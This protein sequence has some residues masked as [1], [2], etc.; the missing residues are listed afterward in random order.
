MTR[1]EYI[2]K[3]MQCIDEVHPESQ[4]DISSCYSI[5]RFLDDAALE[6]LKIAPKHRI[7]NR[8]DFADHI[9][10]QT[11]ETTGRIKTPEDFVRLT[12]LRMDGWHRDAVDTITP[13]DKHYNKKTHHITGGGVSKP[14]V[15]HDGN[16]LY[17]YSLPKGS[18]HTI[19][20]AE[21][22]ISTNALDTFDAMIADCVIWLASHK[23][24]LITGET[25][26][27]TAAQEH[28]QYKLSIL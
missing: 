15:V 4:T 11:G 12:R 10:E 13:S 21:A 9:I 24:L 5:D 28:F 22:I 18:Q 1:E 2:I 19:L 23:I 8:A 14:V 27:A 17:Y 25:Q 26:G 20:N 16:W 6:M 7:T 3:I